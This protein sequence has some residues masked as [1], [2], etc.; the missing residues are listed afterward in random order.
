MG[1]TPFYVGCIRQIHLG[2][3]K[4]RALK[5]GLIELTLIRYS[6][7]KGGKWDNTLGDNNTFIH[8]NSHF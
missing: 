8:F 1:A 6:L 7:R 2:V 5:I 4:A 3:Q